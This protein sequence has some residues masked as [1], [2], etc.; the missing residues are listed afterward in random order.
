[1]RWVGM[2][3]MTEIIRVRRHTKEIEFAFQ[4]TSLSLKLSMIKS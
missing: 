3:D 4:L 1:M 2:A